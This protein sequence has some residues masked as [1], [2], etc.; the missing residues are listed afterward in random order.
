MLRAI[1][2]STAANDTNPESYVSV[3]VR[4]G[5][6]KAETFPYRDKFIPVEVYAQ[7]SQETWDRVAGSTTQKAFWVASDSPDARLELEKMLPDDAEVFSLDRSTDLKLRTLA[8]PR[9]YVQSEFNQLDEST[10]IAQTRGAVIDFAL[11]SGAWA[12]P[13]EAYPMATICALR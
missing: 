1:S 11:L 13:G 2:A 4:R 3:H 9:E 5:D 12:W 10:R 6:R 7:A 8:S